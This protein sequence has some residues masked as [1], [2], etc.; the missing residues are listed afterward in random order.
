MKSFDNNL[1]RVLFGG[2]LLVAAYT[3]PIWLFAS[4]SLVGIALFTDYYEA[5][6]LWC[7]LELAFGTPPSSWSPFVF[8]GTISMLLGVVIG[9]AI[10]RR[11][12][13]N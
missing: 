6:L 1:E 8:I 11:V 2:L 3:M 5:P 4:L 10:K 12:F 9:E 13:V 7:I